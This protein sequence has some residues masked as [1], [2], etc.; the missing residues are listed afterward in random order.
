MREPRAHYKEPPMEFSGPPSISST[1]AFS[2]KGKGKSRYLTGIATLVRYKV[3]LS[4]KR[5]RREEKGGLKRE[6]R[7]VKNKKFLG[8]DSSQFLPN[9]IVLC[10][11]LAHST[12]SRQL[13]Q[14][15]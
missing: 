4:Y 11:S 14:V 3:D 7:C 1:M 6:R 2:P 8:R 13:T 5:R 9:K 15:F 12:K 10:A